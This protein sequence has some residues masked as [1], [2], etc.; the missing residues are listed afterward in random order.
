MKKKLHSFLFH[1]G[2]S[3]YRARTII[4]SIFPDEA[5]NDIEICTAEGLMRRSLKTNTVLTITPNPSQTIANINYSNNDDPIEKIEIFNTEGIFIKTLSKTNTI[6]VIDL[7]NGM[8]L[9]KCITASKN[10]YTSKITV[11]Q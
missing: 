1:N 6:P 8:Y 10:I 3:V 11:I 7:P 9:V 5:Y 2:S 4:A